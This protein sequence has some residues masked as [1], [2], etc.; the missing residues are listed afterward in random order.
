MPPRN[1]DPGSN[2]ENCPKCGT[3]ME[4]IEIEVEGL[5]LQQLQLCPKC[6]LVT[7]MDET[8]FQIRQGVPV[9]RDR[10]D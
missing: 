5:P 8:G 4:P 9:K 3:E 6:Y 7:W 10:V 2:E 1:G